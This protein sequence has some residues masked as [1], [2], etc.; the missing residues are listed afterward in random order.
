VEA[1]I[2]QQVKGMDYGKIYVALDV[3]RTIDEA[4]PSSGE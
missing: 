3:F 1:N 2:L 4:E